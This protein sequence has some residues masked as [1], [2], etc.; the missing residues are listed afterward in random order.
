MLYALRRAV[1]SISMTTTTTDAESPLLKTDALGLAA[2]NHSHLA[3]SSSWTAPA[4][5]QDLI[6]VA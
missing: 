5:Q 6:A 4:G 2:T 1:T 3:L